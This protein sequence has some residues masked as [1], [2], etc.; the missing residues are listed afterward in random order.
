MRRPCAP[1]TV[2]SASLVPVLPTRAGDGDD[3][4][5]R[6]A[7]RAA[8]PSAPMASSTSGTATSSG[9][10]PRTR[11]RVPRATTAAAA[12]FASAAATKSW[13]SRAS[14]LMAKNSRPAASVRV[15][16]ETPVTRRQALAA[17]AP[18]VAAA[19]ICPVGPQ[20]LSVM[21]RRRL[22][23]RPRRDRLVVGE[24]QVPV[25][26]DLAGLV[27]LAGDEQHVAR[28]QLATAGADRLGRGRRSRARPAPPARISARIA[29]GSSVRGLSSVTMTTSACRAA[30]SPMIGRLPRS[31]SPPQPKTHDEPARRV[32]AAARRARAPARRACG[33]SRRRRARR[34]ARPTSSSRP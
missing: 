19:Q 21:R 4:R 15:S 7:R 9:P 25:A 13:P 24:R 23:E 11:R 1:G 27:A 18:P 3:A 5:R 10:P 17:P 28:L 8:G 33:R 22:R 6:C 20:R 32:R 12:P 26:D 2:R 31:R 29:A 30:I 16:M 34:R 14:P